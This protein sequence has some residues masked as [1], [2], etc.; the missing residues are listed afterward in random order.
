MKLSEIKKPTSLESYVA[1]GETDS[2]FLSGPSAYVS[3][4][5]IPI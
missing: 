4:G 3:T 5:P 2:S 1:F